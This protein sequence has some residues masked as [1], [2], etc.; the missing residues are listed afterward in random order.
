MAVQSDAPEVVLR[1]AAVYLY[2]GISR[3]TFWLKKKPPG[4]F[5]QNI[6]KILVYLRIIYHLSS[7]C[8]ILV[9]P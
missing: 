9:N 4:V 8:F 6:G 2:S 3:R 7:P 1:I 5:I